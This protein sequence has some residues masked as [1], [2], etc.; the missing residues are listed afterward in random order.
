MN[1]LFTLLV[2]WAIGS[3][4]L[5]ADYR[6]ERSSTLGFTGTFQGEEFNGSFARF[7]AQIRYDSSVL[8]ASSFDV[9][10][11]LSSVHTGDSDRDEM[12][13]TAEFFDTST[14]ATAHFK[15]SRFYKSGNEVIASGTLTLKGVSKPVDLNVTFTPVGAGATLDIST[16]IKRLDFGIGT[17][18]YADTSTIGNDVQI[19]AHLKLGP[20]A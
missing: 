7:E 13:P 14:S 8:D 9:T 10:I 11:D 2:L 6:V 16:R 19:K 5:A 3:N 17:G 20:K 18:E 15:T 4:A 12:L 1:R